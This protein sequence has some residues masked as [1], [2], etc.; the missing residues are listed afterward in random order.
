VNLNKKRKITIG[1]RLIDY[2]FLKEFAA[3]EG[4]TIEQ[5]LEDEI[6][7]KMAKYYEE[8]DDNQEA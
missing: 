6:A 4:K 1:V 5:Y 2:L 3:L 8:E 7:S